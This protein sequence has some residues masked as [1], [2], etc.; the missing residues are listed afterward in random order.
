MLIAT[1]PLIVAIVGVLMYAL[2][3]NPK[4]ADI[5]RIMF[6]CGLFVTLLLLGH[7]GAVKVLP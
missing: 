5:G 7:D 4:L 6:L 2:A 1:I 3:A